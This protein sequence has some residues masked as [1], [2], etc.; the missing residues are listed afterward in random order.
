MA[1]RQWPAQSVDVVNFEHEE[2][3]GRLTVLSS[4][5]LVGVI[6]AEEDI[7]LV[8]V[9]DLGEPANGLASG[10]VAEVLLVDGRRVAPAED[11]VASLTTDGESLV[12]A[13]PDVL[14]LS[15]IAGSVDGV[16]VNRT[17]VPSGEGSS[18]RVSSDGDGSSLAGNERGGRDSRSSKEHERCEAS[19]CGGWW[20]N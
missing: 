20:S 1:P 10:S 7:R 15:S 11:V 16:L 3:S 8:A 4:A 13:V 2:N 12:K 18:R 19:H 9:D 17:G 14:V 5:V 6:A